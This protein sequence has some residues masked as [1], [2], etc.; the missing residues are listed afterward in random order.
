M[1]KHGDDTEMTH[2]AEHEDYLKRK[3]RL[4]TGLA[5]SV[6]PIELRDGAWLVGS[7]SVD[8][9]AKVP[10]GGLLRSFCRL[11]NATPQR[12]AKFAQQYGLLHLCQE[13]S[14]PQ[15]HQ[16]EC[17]ARSFSKS[18]F[19]PCDDIKDWWRW[20]KRFE[21]TVEIARAILNRVVPKARDVDDALGGLGPRWDDV[22]DL[23]RRPAWMDLSAS[24]VAPNGTVV[25]MPQ[26]WEDQ[27]PE[28]Q[29][30]HLAAWVNALLLTAHVGSRVVQPLGQHSLAV[31]D[32]FSEGTPLFG[33]LAIEVAAACAGVRTIARCRN[34]R[35]GFVPARASAV[36][37]RKCRRPTIRWR[38]AQRARRAGFKKGGLTARGSRP[39]IRRAVR[40]RSRGL[41]G[42]APSKIGGKRSS[43]TM[44]P[45]QRTARARKASK[46][47]ATARRVRA[48]SSTRSRPEKN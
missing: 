46:A 12:I 4:I 44:T 24:R 9:L 43:E 6:P 13:H 31:V 7:W 34:C 41:F 47:A 8:R 11:K 19:Q 17:S 30:F 33:A 28:V 20:A 21:A 45:A 40:R 42:V 15:W 25:Q 16:P 32:G 35:D 10:A 29:I 36:Y 26:H 39:K 38:L 2:F 1:S 14:L 23:L 18:S 3:Q 37:C 48:R 22:A 27:P 5:W